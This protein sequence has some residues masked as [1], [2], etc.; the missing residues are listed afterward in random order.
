MADWSASQY[1]KFADERTRPARDLLAQVRLDHPRRVV[2]AGCG[3]G[4]STE[5]LVRRWRRAEVR[6]FDTSPAMLAEARRRL[7]GISFELVDAAQWRPVEKVDLIFA[8]AVFQWLPEHPALLLRLMDFL[9][10]G[11]VLAVQMPDNLAEPTHRLMTETAA[12]MPFSAR[13]KGAGRSPLPSPAYY[14]DLLRPKAA[15]IDIWHTVYNHPMMD[16]EAIVEWVK[17]TGLKPF[18][19]PLDE[20]ERALFLSGYRGRIAHAYPASPV[21]TI[22]LH[23]PRLFIVAEAA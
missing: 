7:P 21:G 2:D 17:A 1:L 10:P 23:F 4:N 22:L 18:L 11:G 13:L 3:P 16:T 9:V 20:E 14:Y 6:G 5:L 12:A 19:D 8:N 15:R